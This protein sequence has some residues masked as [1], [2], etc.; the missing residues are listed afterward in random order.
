MSIKVKFDV[1]LGRL[2]EC[3]QGSSPTPQPVPQITVTTTG[4]NKT[5]Y[6]DEQQSDT[7]T[8]V[9][10]V[11]FNGQLVDADS[12]PSGWTRTSTGTYERTITEPGQIA[13]QLWSYTPG[14]EYGSQTATA[15]S[16]AR[17]L[18]RVFPAYWGIYP[19]ND[20]SGDISAIVAAL[21][22][23]HRVTQYLPTTVVNVDNPTA[24]DCWMWIVTR[25]E[26]RATP[27]AFDISMM[28]APVTGK[29]FAS[30]MPGANWNLSGYKAYV[31][32]NRADA[33]LSFGPV[34]LTINLS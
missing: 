20:A 5:F 21:K 25:G 34:K 22:D 28:E 33:G 19:G 18:T 23:Q 24:N 29:T 8:V 12:T 15:Y 1:I 13:R 2:R 10:T 17:S 16:E 11:K 3:C 4:S 14:G 27:E 6:A 9:V 31:S 26:A 7:L 30:P 32:I